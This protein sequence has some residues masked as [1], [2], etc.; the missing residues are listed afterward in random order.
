MSLVLV[1]IITLLYV[2][3]IFFLFPFIP[4]LLK[5]ISTIIYTIQLSSQLYTT[6]INPGIPNRSNYVS[7]E[8]IEQISYNVL[9]NTNF[10]FD[11]YRL[12][13]TCNIFIEKNSSVVHCPECEI[14]VEEFDHHCAGIGKC[15]A[16]RN[17]LSF[18]IFVTFTLV[19]FFYSMCLLI[20][21]IVTGIK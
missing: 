14:C 2:L 16:K 5:A 4:N 20:F 19:F 7:D 11:K 9:N 8:V 12:C 15:I 6:L 3:Q 21:T 18:K 17:L 13:K 10:N 1:C